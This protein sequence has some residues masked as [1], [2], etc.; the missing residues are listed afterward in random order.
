MPNQEIIAFLGNIFLI[1]QLLLTGE[2]VSV[3]IQQGA[4]IE[5]FPFQVRF[6]SRW[7]NGQSCL[8]EKWVKATIF[9]QNQQKYHHISFQNFLGKVNLYVYLGQMLHPC[10]HLVSAILIVSFAVKS[11]RREAAGLE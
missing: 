2:A 11:S 5:N 3:F 7:Y 9:Y 8:T 10:L 4:Q 1:R 6:L